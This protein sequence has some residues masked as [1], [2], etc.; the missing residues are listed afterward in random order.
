MKQ[1]RSNDPFQFM[2]SNKEVILQSVSKEA[3]LP[4]AWKALTERIPEIESEIRYNTFKVYAPILVKFGEVMEEK[5]AQLDKVRQEADS[6]KKESASLQKETAPKRFR[7]WGVQLNKGYY[8]LFKKIDGK[9]RWIYIG[10][11]W[12]QSIADEKVN[13]FRLDKNG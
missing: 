6:L 1:N 4:K 7:G 2:I 8:R 11:K 5:E 3:S 12:N 10:K 13:Q 9:V